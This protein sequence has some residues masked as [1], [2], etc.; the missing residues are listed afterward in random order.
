MADPSETTQ[1]SVGPKD[2]ES[3][4]LLNAVRALS[5]QVGGLQTELE[6]LRSQN[7]P[8]PSIETDTHGWEDTGAITPARRA[9]S[10]WVRSLDGPKARRPPVPRL[11]LEVVFLCAVALAAAIAE[12]EPAVIVVLMAIAWVL[13]ALAEWLAARAARSHADVLMA[14]LAGTTFAD[15]RSWFGPPVGRT[16]LDTGESGEPGETTQEEEPA[17]A[18]LPPSSPS[19]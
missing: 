11:L 1:V 5:A 15:D 13:V 8:L 14:P 3:V 4:E 16:V 18:K 12:L 10:P 7:R 2:A 6:A 17:A 19:A 9:S